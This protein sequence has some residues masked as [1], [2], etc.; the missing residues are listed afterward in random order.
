MNIAA[1]TEPFRN[2]ITKT[3]QYNFLKTKKDR[4]NMKTSL[5][6]LIRIHV[7]EIRIHRFLK[8]FSTLYKLRNHSKKQTR[9]KQLCLKCLL[10]MDPK[11]GTINQQMRQQGTSYLI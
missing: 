4:G 9:L 10:S 7:L 2:I 5:K 8:Y 11:E 6:H 3:I 1:F